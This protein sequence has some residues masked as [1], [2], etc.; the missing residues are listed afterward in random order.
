MDIRQNAEQKAGT[1]F[2]IIIAKTSGKPGGPI[3]VF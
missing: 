1:D 2:F 3:T